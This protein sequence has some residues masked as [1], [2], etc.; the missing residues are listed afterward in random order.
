LKALSSS[1][2]EEDDTE[3]YNLDAYSKAEDGLKEEVVWG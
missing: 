1:R 2:V 3:A